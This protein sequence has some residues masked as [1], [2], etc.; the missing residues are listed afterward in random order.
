MNII[1]QN[2]RVVSKTYL[3]KA[4]LPLSLTSFALGIGQAVFRFYPAIPLTASL[5]VSGSLLAGIGEVQS[6]G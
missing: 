1:H 2:S 4:Q 5:R 6:V 3:V